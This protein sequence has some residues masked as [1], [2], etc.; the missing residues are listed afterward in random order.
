MVVECGLGLLRLRFQ[1][2]QWLW[3]GLHEF[4]SFLGEEKGGFQF[5]RILVSC[6]IRQNISCFTNTLQDRK[7]ALEEG[8][9]VVVV[10]V[11]VVQSGSE[12]QI[13]FPSAT[14]L[15]P[16]LKA[17]GDEDTSCTRRQLHR[18]HSSKFSVCV[19]SKR[20]I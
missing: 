18:N 8:R 14:C 15:A 3:Q 12:D 4:A 13:M 17:A 5:L 7:L 2:E 19:T 10:A 16:L 20:D 11:V 1:G 6:L 9:W